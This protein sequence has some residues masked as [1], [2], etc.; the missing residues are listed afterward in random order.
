MHA[1]IKDCMSSGKNR[2]MDVSPEVC[3]LMLFLPLPSWVVRVVVYLDQKW[4]SI[5]DAH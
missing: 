4:F 5:L 1:E 2:G 3:G